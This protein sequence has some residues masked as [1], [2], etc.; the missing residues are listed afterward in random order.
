MDPS[1]ES[2][3]PREL[4]PF[5]NDSSQCIGFLTVLSNVE[6]HKEARNSVDIHTFSSLVQYISN[7]MVKSIFKVRNFLRS[8]TCC[9]VINFMVL[10]DVLIIV[11]CTKIR[12][13][14]CS[15]V[16][17]PFFPSIDA[18]AE[19]HSYISK[20]DQ[21]FPVINCRD[22]GEPQGLKVT[23]MNLLMSCLK[24]KGYIQ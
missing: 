4:A 8:Y 12:Q 3:Q 11:R 15:R 19:K 2:V 21:L 14:L 23:P 22:Q 9:N 18:I 1:R 13:C 10:S 6:Q 17:Y 24:D 20:G 5:R 7:T 16:R